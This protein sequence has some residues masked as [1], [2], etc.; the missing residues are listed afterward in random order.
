LK[1]MPGWRGTAVVVRPHAFARR[2]REGVD[3]D[4]APLTRNQAARRAAAGGL[5][6]T[7]TLG[8]DPARLGA[9]VGAAD[10]RAHGELRLVP[11]A[12]KASDG[13]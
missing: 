10:T 7:R 3:P 4:P 6:L 12:S 11:P 8:V 9:A 13:R 5:Y 2:P 1:N